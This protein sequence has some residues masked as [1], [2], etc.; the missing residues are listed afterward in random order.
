MEVANASIPRQYA[1]EIDKLVKSGEFAS[2]NEFV[3]Y[4]VRDALIAR[5][6]A[7]AITLKKTVEVGS[8][9]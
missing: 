4:A 3:R 5:G 6:L 9:G 1:D 2:R 8:H 7:K